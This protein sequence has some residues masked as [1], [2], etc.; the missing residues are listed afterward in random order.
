MKPFTLIALLMISIMCFSQEKAKDQKIRLL[1]YAGNWINTDNI[2][3]NEISNNPKIKVNV[4]PVLNNTSLHVEVYERFNDNWKLIMVEIISYDIETNQIVAA[5]Q[6]NEGQCFIGKGYFDNN[7]QLKMTDVNYKGDTILTVFF[8]F[9]NSTEVILKGVLPN[10]EEAWKIKYIKDNPKHKNI[11][12]QLISVKDEMAN[13]HIGTLEQLGR[14]GYS[15]IETFVY[16]NR[17][18]YDLSPKEFKAIVEKSGMKF[19]G[20]MVFKDLPDNGDLKKTITWW[21]ECIQD[22]QDAGVEYITTSNNEIKKMKSLDRLK[23]YCEYYNTIGKMC[24]KEDIRFGIHN[25]AEEFSK[26]EG[27]VVY[28]FLLN[29]TDPEFVSFQA[30]LY[31]MRIGGVNPVDYF[32][33]YPGRFFSWHVKDNEELGTSKQVDFKVIYS[34]AEKAGLEYNIVEVEKYNYAPLQS[35]EI[36]YRY[37]FYADFINCFKRK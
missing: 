28:D 8:N 4:T 29:N 19:T 31:W 27:E 21:S 9:M 17:K 22:H 23:K 5:G 11:G 2:D 33:K 34:Y 36:S 15:F 14:I 7:N 37:L 1:Q 18:F 20:S 3:D 35:V 13:D 12:I 10:K 30:D 6:N 24:K 32:N 26:I 16:K 25:H